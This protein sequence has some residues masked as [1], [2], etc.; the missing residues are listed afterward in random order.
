[1][2]HIRSS[3]RSI[4]FRGQTFF[5]KG[6]LQGRLKQLNLEQDPGHNTRQQ[7]NAL[8]NQRLFYHKSLKIHC[9]FYPFQQL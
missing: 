6:Q 3:T 8:Q 5:R 4:T 2:P 9:T 1:M 7:D